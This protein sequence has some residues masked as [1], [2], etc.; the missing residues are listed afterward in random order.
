MWADILLAFFVLFEQGQIEVTLKSKVLIPQGEHLVT[1]G[2]ASS[3]E[4]CWIRLID[5]WFFRNKVQNTLQHFSFSTFTPSTITLYLLQTQ[6]AVPLEG[7]SR[8]HCCKVTNSR[9]GAQHLLVGAINDCRSLKIKVW[10]TDR[11]HVHHLG[12]VR[13]V[14]SQAPP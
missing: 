1:W 2:H 3:D 11:Q 6:E 14:K 10:P 9:D 8:K 12:A 13:N 5:L 7:L 4:L